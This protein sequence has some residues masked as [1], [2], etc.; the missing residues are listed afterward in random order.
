[1]SDERN[2]PQFPPRSTI[3]E[4]CALA[5]IS[6]PTAYDRI[7]RGLLKVVKDGRRTFVSGEELARYLS[8]AG[9]K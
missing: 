2:Q 4:F 5:K 1:M 7:K 9:A 6:R 3:P 8:G